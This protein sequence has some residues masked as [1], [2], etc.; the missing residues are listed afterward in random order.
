[1]LTFQPAVVPQA[2][3]SLQQCATIGAPSFFPSPHQ[4]GTA[5]TPLARRRG[6]DE[7]DASD[8]SD[9][10]SDGSDGEAEERVISML[11]SVRRK[12]IVC[13]Y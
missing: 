1:M 7:D 11:A 5:S 13:G 3:S 6:N 10:V 9:D 4:A 8:G 12:T 2:F